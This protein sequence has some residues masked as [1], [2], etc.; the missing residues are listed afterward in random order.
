VNAWD[1]VSDTSAL[2]M[3]Y[4]VA[5]AQGAN[6]EWTSWA[7]VANV[8]ANILT[9]ATS[10]T[11]EA[12]DEEGNVGTVSSPLI[13]GRADSTL[14]AS[15]SGCGSCKVA[16]DNEMSNLAPM[17]GGLALLFVRR[18]RKNQNAK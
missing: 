2:Q 15:G 3:R 10:L 12:R 4:R 1:I 9:G 18:R 5:N 7:S 16:N 17:L 11:V 8:D 14:T 13:R 6:G